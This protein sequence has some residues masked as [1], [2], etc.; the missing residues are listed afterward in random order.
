MNRL[1]FLDRSTF[2]GYDDCN[3][4]IQGV[5]M[6]PQTRKKILT[7][8]AMAAVTAVLI[9]LYFTRILPAFESAGGI[10]GLRSWLQSHTWLGRA[11]FLLMTVAQIVLAFIPGEPLEMAAGYAFGAAEGT[12]LCIIGI[13]AG[14]ALV[15]CLVRTLGMRIIRVFFD[16]EK[17]RQL[18]FWQNRRRLELIAFILFLIPGTPKD[19]MTYAIGLTPLPLH[20]WLLIT[21]TAR[22]PS[23]LTSTLCADAVAQGDYTLAAIMFILSAAMA[24]AG[25]LYYRRSSAKNA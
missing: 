16:P 4:R 3:F 24:L 21:G 25:V 9:W 6:K 8:L 10:E 7:L 19:M 17:I 22:L 11:V 5:L 18:P 12:I 14:S 15:Y 2:L 23:V 20:R 1:P 13:V